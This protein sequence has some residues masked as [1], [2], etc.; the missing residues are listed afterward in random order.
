MALL[1]P[2]DLVAKPGL[3]PVGQL[4]VIFVLALLDGEGRIGA[5][6]LV[7]IALHE[8]GPGFGVARPLRLGRPG[9]AERDRRRRQEE[10]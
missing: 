2:G 4:A 9:A 5:E 6:I 10:W 1:Q 3:A 7:D 8:G